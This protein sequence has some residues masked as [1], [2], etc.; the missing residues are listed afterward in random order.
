MPL[1]LKC[2]SLNVSLYLYSVLC[3]NKSSTQKVVVVLCF[4][5]FCKSVKKEDKKANLNCFEQDRIC[6]QRL[7]ISGDH[8]WQTGNGTIHLLLS[9]AVTVSILN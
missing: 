5:P 7:K 1:I 9:G 6:R 2:L 4:L 3:S 8:L